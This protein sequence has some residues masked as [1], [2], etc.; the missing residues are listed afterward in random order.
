MAVDISENAAL[1]SARGSNRNIVPRFWPSAS[2][3]GVPW[4]VAHTKPLRESAVERKLKAEG[5]AVWLPVMSHIG[6][7]RQRRYERLF[8]RYILLQLTGEREKWGCTIRSDGGEE[9]ASVLRTPAG[10]PLI[11]PDEVMERLLVQCA[12]DGIIHEPEPRQMRRGDVARV[13]QGPFTS[14]SGVCQ[15]TSKDRVWLL[16]TIMGRSTEVPF[17]R[18]D[19]ELVA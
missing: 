6:T 11:V 19:V 12:P 16:L 5:A 14:F 8:P 18:S 13:E 17:K 3:Q 2:I 10:V 9:L 4:H 15:R 1:A 7:N